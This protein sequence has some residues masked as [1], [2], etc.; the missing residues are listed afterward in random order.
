MY[1]RFWIL[2]VAARIDDSPQNME[3][4]RAKS[5]RPTGMKKWFKFLK[6]RAAADNSIHPP[7]APVRHLPE[8]DV[9]GSQPITIDFCGLN[10]EDRTI[11]IPTRDAEFIG[12]RLEKMR[13]GD[14]WWLAGITFENC[15][16]IDCDLYAT[17]FEECAFIN[18][19]FEETRLANVGFV[20][21]SFDNTCFRNCLLA[22]MFCGYDEQT[23]RSLIQ[24]GS[25]EVS[26]ESKEGRGNEDEQF[27]ISKAISVKWY[28]DYGAIRSISS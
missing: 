10:Y 23:I 14:D 3:T 6:K 11:T 2:L 9:P 26:V 28:E 24:N 18:C 19:T 1:P 15:H 13:Q 27:V 17:Q 21:C 12:W 20:R 8:W 22:T 5:R 16:F 7:Q 4:R 25:A